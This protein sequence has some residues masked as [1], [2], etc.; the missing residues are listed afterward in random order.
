MQLF[1]R[2][3]EGSVAVLFLL[4]AIRC[5]EQ[6]G[7]G[8][9]M[10]VLDARANTLEK[11]IRW[12]RNTILNNEKRFE[13]KAGKPA[14][15]PETSLFTDEYME[16]FAGRWAPIGASNDPTGLNVNWLRNAR[17]FHSKCIYTLT[18]VA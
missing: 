1:L 6:G 18:E 13:K 5:A 17:F 9:E 3:A 10:G 7:P 2:Y 4:L 14:R 11:Q 15:H 12:A 8:K 16:F